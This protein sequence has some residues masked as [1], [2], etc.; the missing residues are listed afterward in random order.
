MAIASLRATTET[1]EIYDDPSEDLLFML[2]EDIAN[3]DEDFFI[4]ERTEGGGQTYF[5]VAGGGRGFVLEYRDGGP[6]RH[7]G[8]ECDDLQCAHRV[9]TGWALE[10]D[11][12]RNGLA[13]KQIRL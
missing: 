6:D 10:L 2:F 12:W 13:W 7:F 1:G 11:E 4:V 3:G 8:T 9:V 5:Q